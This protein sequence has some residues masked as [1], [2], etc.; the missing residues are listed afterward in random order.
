MIVSND[1]NFFRISLDPKT[2]CSTCGHVGI[3]FLENNLP[4]DVL[5]PGKED[6]NLNP[7]QKKTWITEWNKEKLAASNQPEQTTVTY[8]LI[9]RMCI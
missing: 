9:C 3:S 5:Y 4:K 7:V 8:Y 1:I 6:A 2:S